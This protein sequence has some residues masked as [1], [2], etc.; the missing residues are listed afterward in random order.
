M[1]YKGKNLIP[2]PRNTKYI[3]VT[4]HTPNNSLNM[5]ITDI[6]AIGDSPY[7]K[8]GENVFLWSFVK[9]KD[10][11]ILN[12]SHYKMSDVYPST[13]ASMTEI[14]DI[15]DVTNMIVEQ[16]KYNTTLSIA[17]MF[18]GCTSLN[19]ISK[20]DFINNYD[21]DEGK[22]KRAIYQADDYTGAFENCTSL[23][24]VFPIIF[25]GDYWPI[26]DNMFNGSSVEEVS[27]RYYDP[28]DFG[29]QD[30]I[31]SCNIT[32]ENLDPNGTLKKINITESSSA[33]PYKV[34]TRA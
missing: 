14:P 28:S 25:D 3:P 15:L 27:F 17:G 11:K 33:A 1:Q 29:A 7:C 9:Q 2:A 10:A 16:D 8:I 34:I 6:E 30:F 18:K 12:A 24:K 13:Y 32:C 20:D 4:V 31:S 23:P 21:G 22:Y 19:T 26:V 5:A